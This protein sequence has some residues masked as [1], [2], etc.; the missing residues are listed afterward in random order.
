MLGYYGMPEE[1]AN[2]LR[3]HSDGRVWAHTGDLGYMDEQG[4]VYVE[5]RIK[6]I[7]IRHDGFKVFPS[8]DRKRHQPPPRLCQ[9]CSVVGCADKDHVQGRLPF[10]YLVLEPSAVAKKKQVIRELREMCAEGLP[11]Y[12]QPI[13]YK[14]ISSMPMTPIGKVDYR[15]LEEEVSPRDY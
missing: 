7:I 11:E 5:S 15:R 10:V 1:T 9:Q 14:F 2:L 8:H 6:R 13:A 12:V 4:F 3:R